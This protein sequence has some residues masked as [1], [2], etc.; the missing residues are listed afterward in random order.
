MVPQP[1]APTMFNTDVQFEIYGVSGDKASPTGVVLTMA[2]PYGT[3]P[4]GQ[5]LSVSTS[6]QANPTSHRP[7]GTWAP[8]VLQAKAP[9]SGGP[10]QIGPTILFNS[11]LTQPWRVEYQFYLQGAWQAGAGE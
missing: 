6:A 9:A 11:G 5:L 8:V 2:P 3:A 4:N 10:F 7:F 1:G